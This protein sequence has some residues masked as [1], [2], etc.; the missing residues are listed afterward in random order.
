[1]ASCA[2]ST[3]PTLCL[4][5]SRRST[6]T[7][8][9]LESRSTQLLAR[10]PGRTASTSTPHVLQGDA[11]SAS[12]IHALVVPRVPAATDKLNAADSNRTLT[13]SRSLPTRMPLRDS[14]S[15]A[16]PQSE[17]AL[18]LC[19]SWI[20]PE[21]RMSLLPL[22]GVR[23][24][25]DTR[26]RAKIQQ[27]A[28]TVGERTGIGGAASEGGLVSESLTVS[29]VGLGA[30]GSALARAIAGTGHEL[31]VWN[32]SSEKC[33]PLA[34]EGASVASSVGDA[35]SRS[36]VVANRT[37]R[38]DHHRGVIPQPTRPWSGGHS[39]LCRPVGGGRYVPPV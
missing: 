22:F 20:Q 39:T 23:F 33:R 2:N 3:S 5:C 18:S 11:A 14:V 37:R 30:M 38:R 12:A 1:M 19:A 6:M 10:S 35:V 21:G 27:I 7:R 9:S 24:D 29:V 8:S 34:A 26:N 36:D 17:A 16:G 28:T 13:N 25:L 15:D 31:T 4:V 32:R